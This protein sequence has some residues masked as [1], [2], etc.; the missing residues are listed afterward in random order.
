MSVMI[1]H[2]TSKV[3][4]TYPEDSAVEG[5][6]L[7]LNVHDIAILLALHWRH[8]QSLMS[9][10]VELL[11]LTIYRLGRVKS[12]NTVL[13]EGV[14]EHALGHLQ[15]GEQLVNILVLLCIGSIDL[16]WR[17]GSKGTLQVIN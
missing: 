2:S 3:C 4:K 6:T 1:R 11:R 5:E 8:E 9:A 13:L 12:D 17:N 10:W 7:V 16:L 15:A 14:H